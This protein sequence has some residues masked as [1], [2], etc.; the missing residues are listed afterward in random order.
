MSQITYR[1]NLSAKGFPFIS[2]NEGRSIIVS[3]YD[4]AFNRQ[5]VSAEDQDKDIGIP[6]VYY[7]HNVMPH[8][9]G[10][11][12]V[13]FQTIIASALSGMYIIF[14]LRDNNN[15]RCYLGVDTTGNFYIYTGTGTWINKGT[16]PVNGGLNQ[17]S[18]AFCSGITYIYVQGYGCFYYDFT[19]NAFV[20]VV[21]SGLVITGAGAVIGICPSAGYMVA[22][23]TT[24]VA[25][26]STISPIDFVP[27]LITGAGGGSVDG[28]R[29]QINFCFPH[30]LG[31]IVYTLANAV[32]A[33]FSGNSRFPFNFREIVASGGVS[34]QNLI[35]LGSDS[36][37]HY[38]Y[39]TSGFQLVSTSNSTTIYPELTDFIG[40]KLFEDFN[41]TLKV[42]VTTVL[43]ST[44]QKA[45]SV[46]AD[47]YLVVS[48]GINS[49]THA[50]IYDLV[51]KRYGKLKVTHVA[52]FEYQ[53]PNPIITEQPRQSIAFLQ[54]NGSIQLVD[55]SVSNPASNGTMLLGKY[56]FVR[57]R[58]LTLDEIN[59]EN[60]RV[61]AAF[62]LTNMYTLD[63]KNY[64]YSTPTLV[65][66]AGLFRKYQTRVTGLNHSLLFQGAF[67]VCSNVLV[68]HINGK[69]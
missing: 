32:A 6:Q 31:F 29:G 11:Q 45:L 39:T 37:N 21:L 42:F 60:F 27:S 30:L 61:G 18:T 19:T 33:L 50:L 16:F 56:Q 57:P 28:A 23:N 26:S 40:G 52:S 59:L 1:G 63:G 13:A 22:W 66:S 12:S 65:L 53:L 68:F 24:S 62:S 14:S 5:V 2:E 51:M 69:R 15:N 41:D 64:L 49:L 9:Q 54:A 43:T 58:L 47:R 3:Q 7:C 44:M 8:P 17:I 35:A 67:Q 46:I 10:F 36:G 34:N 25:W 55:F 48:Y 20:A 4:N 38:T